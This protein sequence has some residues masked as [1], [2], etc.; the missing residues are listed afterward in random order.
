M[1]FITSDFSFKNQA[2][3]VLGP[4][5]S[6]LRNHGQEGTVFAGYHYDTNFLTSHRKSRF[7]GIIFAINKYFT[8]DRI[9]LQTSL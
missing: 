7:P 4:T 9:W 8:N 3:H 1:H 2:P 5:G 6:D